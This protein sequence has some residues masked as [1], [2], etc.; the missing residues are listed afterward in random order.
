M[1]NP[2]LRPENLANRPG[3]AEVRMPVLYHGLRNPGRTVPARPEP[4]EQE[5]RVR[6]LRRASD[7]QQQS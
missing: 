7:L 1:G 4:H 3:A 5:L 2:D 6:L